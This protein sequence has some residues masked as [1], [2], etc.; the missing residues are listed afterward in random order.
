MDWLPYVVIPLVVIWIAYVK[1]K[2]I[3]HPSRKWEGET[4]DAN[5][6]RWHDAEKSAARRPPP[7]GGGG[8]V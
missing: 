3:K 8:G 7:P 2:D 1:Y 6:R 5:E 4:D